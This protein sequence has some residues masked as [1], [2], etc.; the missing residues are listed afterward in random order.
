MYEM[1]KIF[2]AVFCFIIAFLIIFI[3]VKSEEKD[4]KNT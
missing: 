3:I 4:G 1:I 2:G